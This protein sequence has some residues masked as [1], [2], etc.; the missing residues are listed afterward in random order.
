MRLQ[1]CV[2]QELNG[3][4]NGIENCAKAK[5]VSGVPGTV[6]TWKD[7]I[8][9]MRMVDGIPV[10]WT[11][12][13][14]NDGVQI[15]NSDNKPVS[16]L[17][18]DWNWGGE[19]PDEWYPIDWHFVVVVVAKDHTFSGWENYVTLPPPATATPTATSAP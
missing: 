5:A 7:A 14:Y 12:P 19:D 1:Y 3:N 13:R 15:R 9:D 2:W 6:A 10:D 16:D 11:R 18:P 17:N 4:N 8:Q